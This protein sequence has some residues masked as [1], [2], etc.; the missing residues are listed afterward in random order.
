MLSVGAGTSAAATFRAACSG[1][2]GDAGSLV[3]ALAQANATAG[4]DTVSLGPRCTYTLTAPDNYW[5]GPNGLPEIKTD[6]TIEGHGATI[7]RA[8]SAPKFRI[9]FVGADPASPAT[10][11]YTSPGAGVLT[12][13]DVTIRGGLAKGGDSNG[14][15]GGAGMGGAIFSQGTVR[16]ERSTLTGNTAQGGSAV[17][18]SAGPGG[19]GIGTDSPVSGAGGGFGPGIF[20]GGG[21]GAPAIPS[22]GGGGAGFG[23]TENGNPARPMLP[24]IPPP[25]P[26]G[27]GA[28]GGPQTGLGGGGN[29]GGSAGDGSGGGGHNGGPGGSGGGFGAGGG[30]TT[31]GGGGGGGIGGGGGGGFGAGGGQGY[32]AGGTGGFGGG[33][34]GYHPGAPGFG[35]GSPSGDQAGG[36]AGMGGAIFN[37]QGQLTVNDSTI[38]ANTAVGGTDNVPDHG[39]GIGGAVF[40]MSGTFTATGST[41]AANTAAYY[42]AQIYNL[43]YDAQTA[44]TAQTT[45]RDTIVTNGVGPVDVASNK[46]DYIIPANKGTADIDMSQFDLV[47]SSS[48]QEHGTV[49]G[50]PLTADPALGPLADNGGPTATMA[51]APGSP[52]IDA[53]F[54]FG[55]TTD[56][57][58]LRRTFDFPSIPNAGDG[59]DIGA[60]EVQ[61]IPSGGPTPSGSPGSVSRITQLQIK[62]STLIPAG[63]GGPVAAAGA[64]GTATGAVVSYRSTQPARTTFTV[65][66]PVAGRRQGRSCVKPSTRNRK[67][68]RCTR[69]QSLG[70]FARIDAAGANRFR[71]TGRLKGNKL[72]P[73]AYRLRAIPRNQAGVGIAV[74][75]KF[76]VKR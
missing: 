63:R 6:V 43:V 13:R 60:L 28:G 39:K 61:P 20:G 62:P 72:R 36:G 53:G 56:Q 42:A 38:A 45:L 41:F 52:A 3:A 46:T 49:S 2:R 71:F 30:I 17:N 12:L 23:A 11:D 48:A 67:A 8:A 14:G 1:T 7:A 10:K 54:A 26:N 18:T 70:S 57:R 24:G 33:G 16:I 34:S 25:T 75:R 21:G 32:D 44:R 65:Q 40:N 5:Y 47:R 74:F 68:K 37:M 50:S 51:P 76:A 58:G 64:K 29:A 73:G 55:L 27:Y 22:S 69:Y 59:T 9:F 31:G 4:A 35:G 15:G 66:R 19:G